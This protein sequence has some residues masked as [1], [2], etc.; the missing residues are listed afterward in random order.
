[1]KNIILLIFCLLSLRSTLLEAQK[2]TLNVSHE[3]FTY[4]ENGNSVNN[5]DTWDDPTYSVPI[6]FDFVVGGL[7]FDSVHLS[8]FGGGGIVS[9][10][11]NT[12]DLYMGCLTAVCP[13]TTILI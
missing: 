13:L 11:K 2:Y 7:T 6:G 12:E 4:L 10:N 3:D 1:M 9:F 5:G 8:I